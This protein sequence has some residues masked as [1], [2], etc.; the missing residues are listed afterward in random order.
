MSISMSRLS[1]VDKKRKYLVPQRTK[2]VFLSRFTEDE[3]KLW[4]ANV[5]ANR[6]RRR[7]MKKKRERETKDEADEPYVAD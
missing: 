3:G 5:S 2:T 7:N 6:K 1:L 4:A